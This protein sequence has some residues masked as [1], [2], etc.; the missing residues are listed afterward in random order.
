[1]DGT[2]NGLNQGGMLQHNYINTVNCLWKRI[3]FD[4][5]IFN[6]FILIHFMHTP[7]ECETKLSYRVAIPVVLGLTATLGVLITGWYMFTSP[8]VINILN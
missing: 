2:S 3:S 8:T 7:A 6:I 1:M 4:M 5:P